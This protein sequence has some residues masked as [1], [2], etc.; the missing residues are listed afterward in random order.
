MWSRRSWRV[1]ISAVVALIALAA[2]GILL[3][4]HNWPLIMVAIWGG[5]C[6]VLMFVIIIALLIMK[7]ELLA[8]P[9]NKTLQATAATPRR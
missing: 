5:V 2:L 3:D 7:L 4:Y 8:G 1:G 9:A 6:F